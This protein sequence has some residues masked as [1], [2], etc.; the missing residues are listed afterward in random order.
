MDLPLFI[1]INI[2]PLAN[3]EVEESRTRPITLKKIVTFIDL[4]YVSWRE[5]VTF[6]MTYNT[7]S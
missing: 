6:T 5:L 2:A 1:D 4:N 3:T 7:N